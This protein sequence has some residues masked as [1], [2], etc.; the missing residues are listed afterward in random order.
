MKVTKTELEGVLLIEPQYFED[1]R[2]YYVESYSKRTLEQYGIAVDFVQ[3]GHSYS[4]DK[5]IVRGIHFQRAP[6]AQAKL[7]RC[8]RGCVMDVAVDLRK[9]S[10]NYLKWVAVEL[11]W[12]NRRQLFIPRGFGHGFETLFDNC[13]LQYK[14][15]AFYCP[16]EDR[17]IAWND[18]EIGI[19]WG[20]IDPVLSKKDEN[21][22]LLKNS[23][24]NFQF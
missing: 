15:D 5:G 20:V 9:G 4:R 19:V 13:E 16:A 1:E 3:D 10:P 22:P 14:V 21:A 17:S 7:V 8:T 6:Y 18:P 2:G 24:A 12:N 11:S 23:D